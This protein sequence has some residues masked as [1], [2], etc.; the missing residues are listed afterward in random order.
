MMNKLLTGMLAGCAISAAFVSNVA[1]ADDSPYYKSEMSKAK[2]QY[3]SDKQRCDTL[4]GNDRDV[5]KDRASANLK[6]AEAD[7]KAY[8]KNT[9][10]AAIKAEDE[11]ISQEYKVDKEKCDAYKGNAKD[12]CVAQ[13]EATKKRR[14]GNLKALEEKL[15]GEYKLAVEKCENYSGD[16][17]SSCKDEAKRKYKP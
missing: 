8:E 14:E 17:R 10:A 7:L 6:I 9:S 13:A 11:R 4:K 1:F 15:D 5:C 2:A 3:E 12:I 16:K